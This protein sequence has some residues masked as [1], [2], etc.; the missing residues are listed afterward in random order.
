MTLL[1]SLIIASLAVALARPLCALLADRGAPAR[2]FAWILLLAPYFTPVL[3]TG[4]AYAN[5]SLS[6]IHHP[7]INTLFYAALLCW[8]FTPVAA[9]ILYFSP[10]PISAEAIHCRRL[11]Q[12]D[13]AAARSDLT[14]LA[15]L[16]HWRFLL[17]A[18]CARD[19][20]AAFAVVFL[21]TFGEMEMASLMVVKSWTVAL[22]DANAGGL[23]LSESLR[24]MLGPL[25][26]EAAAVATA[27]FVLGR[28]RAHPAPRTPGGGRAHWFAWTYLAIAFVFVLLIPAAMVL[29]GTIRGFKLLLENFVLGREIISSLLFAAGATLLAGAM[30][31]WL[32]RF[33]RGR[34]FGSV[35]GKAILLVAVCLGLLGPLVLS[36]A[37]LAAVQMPGLLSLRDTPVPLVLTL[38]LVL[39]P[40]ALV[41]KRVLELTGYQSGLHL[42]ALMQKSRAARDLT[43]RLSTSGKFWAVVLLFIWAYWDLTASA[44]LA[45]IGMTPVT[46]RLYNMMHYGQIAVLSA[47]TCATFAAPIL[48][49]V[50][51]LGTR[52]WWAPR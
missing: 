39:L 38:G 1:R 34:G 26:C 44:I 18:G 19:P 24:R 7:S 23:A 45:P 25:L 50:L 6:L 36:L 3:L 12:N 20:I 49:C 41:L 35:I 51:A 15:K 5:F 43:W 17:R 11:M 8:K 37:V 21:C 33:A 9:V 4:Y 31:F 40:L 16:N 2:R 47:M 29:W 52:R 42:A 13:A 27:V 22:F 32:S 14:L 30:V 10:A 48:I 46:V 28:N